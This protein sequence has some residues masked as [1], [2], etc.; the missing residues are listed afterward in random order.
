MH[1]MCRPMGEP[2]AR[3]RT[4]PGQVLRDTA[5]NGAQAAEIALLLWQGDSTCD[6]TFPHGCK[7]QSEMTND[8]CHAR[9]GQCR[10]KAV[11]LV[12]IFHATPCALPSLCFHNSAW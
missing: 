3:A 9:L 4:I 8:L 6:R 5:K 12:W 10:G 2:P 7:S 1:I 11:S